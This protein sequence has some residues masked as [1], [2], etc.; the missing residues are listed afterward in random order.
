MKF[1]PAVPKL[2]LALSGFSS[3]LIAWTFRPLCCYLAAGK[4]YNIKLIL[5]ISDSILIA[6]ALAVEQAFTWCI[7]QSRHELYKTIVGG[8]TVCTT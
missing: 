3:T 7:L 6:L 5:F 2:S 1:V 4:N 8:E